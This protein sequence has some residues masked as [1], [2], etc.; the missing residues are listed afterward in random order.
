MTKYILT[1]FS[2]LIFCY[3]YS[4]TKDDIIFIIHIQGST[5]GNTREHPWMP[6]MPKYYTDFGKNTKHSV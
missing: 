3:S 2:D 4:I 6:K 5:T 1:V